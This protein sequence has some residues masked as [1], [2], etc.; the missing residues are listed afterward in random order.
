M[1]GVSQSSEAE[2]V[3]WTLNGPSPATTSEVATATG[4]GEAPHTATVKVTLPAGFRYFAGNAN[5]TPAS[6]ELNVLTPSAGPVSRPTVVTTSAS[7]VLT[8]QLTGLASNTDYTLTF[9]TSPSIALGSS[10][11]TADVRIGSRT[12]SGSSTVEVADSGDA[13]ADPGALGGPIATDTLYLGYV[14]EP[15]DVDLYGFESSPGAQVG[16]RLSHL[17]GDGEADAH[18]GVFIATLADKQ[19]E[20]A[21]GGP[22]SGVGGQK[23][24]PLLQMCQADSFL[25]PRAR[26]ARITARPPT[27]AI[28]DRKP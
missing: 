15:G 7:T 3:N 21:N 12:G 19:N 1:T 22:S 25:R 5:L 28:R 2:P 9:R 20:A 6:S 16:I 18:G 14:N 17:A 23:V 26:R 8:W 10:S 4:D 27:V 24:R 11:A 13:P